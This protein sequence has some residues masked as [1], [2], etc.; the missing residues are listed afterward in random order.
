MSVLLCSKCPDALAPAA[1]RWSGVTHPPRYIGAVTG[2]G[3]L[4][5]RNPV[6]CTCVV[7]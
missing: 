3:G 5:Q 4:A 1:D 2:L 6:G 7:G